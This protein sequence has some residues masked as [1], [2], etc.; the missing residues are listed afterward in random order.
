MRVPLVG[1]RAVVQ[2]FGK[3]GGPLAFLLSSAG[4]RV[5]AISDI[6]G[7]VLNEGGLDVGDLA[8][9]VAET[10][11]VAGFAGGEA[12]SGDAIWD[13]PCELLV[14]CARR[15]HRRPGGRAHRRQAGGRGGQ[16]AHDGRGQPVLDRRGVVVVP[17]IL[18]NAGGVTASYFEWAQAQQGYRGR[19][20]WWPSGCASGWSTPSPPSGL[21]PRRWTSACAP[22][23]R[24]GRAGGRRHHRPRP[25]PVERRMCPEIGR[26]PAQFGQDRCVRRPRTTRIAGMEHGGHH[27][28][29]IDHLVRT[30]H[31]PAGTARR[32]VDDVVAYF[33]RAG[34][35]AG[36]PAPPRAPG[37]RP[38]QRSSTASRPSWR[39]AR[40]QHPPCPPGSSAGSSTARGSSCAGSSDMSATVTLL[41]GAGRGPPA[42]GVPGLRL[43]GGRGGGLLG[44][45]GV[46]AGGPG[47]RAGRRAAQAAE[48]RSA[49]ATPAGHPASPPTPTP[50]PS[51][52]RATWP[53][54]TTASSRMP[55]ELQA[56][57]L[58]DGVELASETDHGD[59][60]ARGPALR[61]Y[62]ARGRRAQGAVDGGGH[63]RPGG[64]RRPAAR[65]HRRGPQRQPGG[66]GGG[67]ARPSWPPT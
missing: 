38:G 11:S 28:D 31:L 30:T 24:G 43:G 10:G 46:Q 56:K 65:L 58:A 48:A 8:D 15:G 32:V 29:L 18:A 47:R 67:L 55:A 61:R 23:R 22:P 36:A 33:Q 1:S 5:V 57:L 2:G 52:R 13:I 45:E 21:R 12:I 26:D 40:W 60:P 39:P 19:T 35:G 37:V 49:S 27:A 54:C 64:G 59:R 4:M 63:L 14:P 66:A 9:H 7:A 42:P 44:P 41:P 20:T 16:R 17:D 51:A 62:V 6:G 3:V 50:I 53:W 34:R 25:V